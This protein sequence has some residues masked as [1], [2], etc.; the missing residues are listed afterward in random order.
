M[1]NISESVTAHVEA[2]ITIL[3][4]LEVS[5]RK[6]IRNMS[7]LIK[8]FCCSEFVNTDAAGYSCLD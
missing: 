8:A 3:R 7:Q 2:K 5:T 1:Q 6:L 4:H